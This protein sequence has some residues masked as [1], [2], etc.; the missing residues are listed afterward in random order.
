VLIVGGLT[1]SGGNVVVSSAELYN[2][3]TGTFTV[4]GSLTTARFVHTATLLSN[5]QVL[6]AGGQATL[7]GNSLSSAEL[8]NPTT[9]TFK[10][11]GNMT[12]ARDDHTATLLPNRQVLITGGWGSGSA[13][14][15]AELYSP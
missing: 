2:P 12:T 3:A 1:G 10:S 11:T 7:N 6:I 15:S 8:Y 4:T 13:L 14:A 5:G 9:G